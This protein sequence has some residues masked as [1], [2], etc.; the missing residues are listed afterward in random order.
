MS[1]PIDAVGIEIPGHRIADFFS[2]SLDQVFE[3]GFHG[4][5]AFLAGDITVCSEVLNAAWTREKLRCEE[6]WLGVDWSGPTPL[7]LIQTISPVSGYRMP[8]NPATWGRHD[9]IDVPHRT[10]HAQVD[11]VVE[12]R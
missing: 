8:M 9:A 6:S 5:T 7:A 10:G 4:A 1:V 3:L 12:R 2:F 11:R